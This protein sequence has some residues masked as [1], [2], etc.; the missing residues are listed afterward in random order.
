VVGGSGGRVHSKVDNDGSVLGL[1]F[2][3]VTL[4]LLKMGVHGHV[5]KDLGRFCS[6]E[7][8]H[9]QDCNIS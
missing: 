8:W 9:V 2:G 7:L 3:W 6:N 1:C 5:L 4:K